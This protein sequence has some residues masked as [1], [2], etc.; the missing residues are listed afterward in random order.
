[1]FFTRFIPKKWLARCQ[2]NGFLRKEKNKNLLERN[3]DFKGS[4]Q[5]RCFILG[6]GPS[7]KNEDLKYLTNEVVFTVNDSFLSGFFGEL[8]TNYHLL[9]DPQYSDRIGEIV[10]KINTHENKPV[11]VTD[12]A[13][14]NKVNKNIFDNDV[15]YLKPGFEID[16]L[17]QFGVHIEKLVPYFCTVV[18][19]ALVL[20]I[21]MGFDQIYLLGCDCTG[22][23]NYMERKKGDIA[24]NYFF[25][26]P[27]DEE[28]KL[29]SAIQNISS[30]HAFY[31]WYHIFKS[32]RLINEYAIKKGV[33]IVDLTSDGVLDVFPKDSLKKILSNHK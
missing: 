10:E 33:K 32:Y 3:C 17:K 8:R 14:A 29:S 4:K 15:I 16:S 24:S 26:I 12:L 27:K 13:N 9:F 22:I 28:K 7:L 11:I 5:G 31:E 1:M 20:A 6:N 21:D 19:F 2:Y 23:I 25:D 18:Q 30:E